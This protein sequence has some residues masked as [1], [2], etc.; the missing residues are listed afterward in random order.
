[1][2]LLEER[3]IVV[4][5]KHLTKEQEAQIRNLLKEIGEDTVACI[6]CETCWPMYEEVKSLVLKD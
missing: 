3:Y 2:K 1:M 6:V 5:L 4:K